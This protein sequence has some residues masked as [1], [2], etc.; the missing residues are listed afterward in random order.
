MVNVP[1][2]ASETCSQGRG[3]KPGEQNPEQVIVML[4]KIIFTQ[5][6]HIRKQQE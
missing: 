5:N 2:A 3:E 6:K 1:D 4:E